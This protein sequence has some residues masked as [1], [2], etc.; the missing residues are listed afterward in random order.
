MLEEDSEGSTGRDETW[1]EET[2]A[3]RRDHRGRLSSILI[4]P[5]TGIDQESTRKSERERERE[6]ER[7]KEK[8]KKKEKEQLKVP[9]G[10]RRH[11][12]NHLPR[13]SWTLLSRGRTLIC[14]GPDPQIPMVLRDQGL[15]GASGYNNFQSETG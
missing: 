8:E 14:R 4:K 10:P 12:K 15:F 1:R 9:I 11:L 7:E 13:R 5:S 2:G 6:R 3:D